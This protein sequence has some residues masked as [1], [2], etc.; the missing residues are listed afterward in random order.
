MRTGKSYVDK[1]DARKPLDFNLSRISPEYLIDQK[2]FYLA[3][4]E[5]Y[6]CFVIRET[7]CCLF[8]TIIKQM[9]LKYLTLPQDI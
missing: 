9:L 6:F 1:L 2:D 5:I 3:C 7:S 8:L 4:N